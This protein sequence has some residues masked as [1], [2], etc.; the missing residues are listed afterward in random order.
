MDHSSQNWKTWLHGHKNALA[1]SWAILTSGQQYGVIHLRTNRT[2][3][4]V[5]NPSHEI[6]SDDKPADVINDQNMS[7][8][9]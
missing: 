7:H 3:M 6:T 8:Y 9:S 4:P 5:Q 1:G 2:V